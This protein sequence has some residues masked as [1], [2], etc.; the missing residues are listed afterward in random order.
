MA[1]GSLPKHVARGRELLTSWSSS[2]L[3]YSSLVLIL[4]VT[5]KPSDLWDALL[6][7]DKR[8][9]QI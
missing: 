7:F 5:T 2:S 4:A 6:Q 3:T 8:L 1:T 9:P